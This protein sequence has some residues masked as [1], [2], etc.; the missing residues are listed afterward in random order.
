MSNTYNHHHPLNSLPIGYCFNEFEIE[1]II[2]KGESGVVYR[3]WDHRLKCMVAIKE[4]IPSS[5]VTRG[6]DLELKLRRKDFQEKFQNGLTSFARGAHVMSC[7]QHPCLPFFRSFWQKNHTAYIARSFYNGIT[8][9]KLLATQAETINQ[10]WIC[11]FLYS[12]LDAINMIHHSDYL[13]GNIALDNILIQENEIPILLGLGSARKL[14]DHFPNEPDVTLR[15]GFTPLE[16]YTTHD[17][18]Q[19]Q[20]GPWTDIY[21]LGAIL[22][23]LIAGTPPPV[24][25]VRNIEDHYQPLVE[26]R[27]AGYSLSFLHAIDCAL[28]IQ[29]AERPASIPQLMALIESSS[30]GISPTPLPLDSD[31]PADKLTNYPSPVEH[32]KK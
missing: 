21:A 19:Q 5:L 13:H 2:G 15:S 3:A 1:T 12:L 25:I 24:S 8:L 28:A 10:R 22:H 9:K 17:D 16:Q 29:P 32:G 4:Y 14:T 11:R 7:F 26:R 30:K 23:T 6:R 27:P 20:K 31:P 18:R